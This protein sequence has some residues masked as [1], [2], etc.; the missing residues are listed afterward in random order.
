MMEIETYSQGERG[1]DK[2]ALCEKAG[3]G[4]MKGDIVMD[5]GTL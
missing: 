1:E 5:K 3:K 2:A 4:T